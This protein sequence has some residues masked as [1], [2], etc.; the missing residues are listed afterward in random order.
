[1]KICI[2]I[3][4]LVVFLAVIVFASCRKYNDE[5]STAEAQLIISFSAATVPI[6][7]T[8]S[9]TTT[10]INGTDTVRKK[11]I[12]AGSFYSISLKDLKNA[13]YTT[14]TK[15]YAAADT[16]GNRFMYRLNGTVDTQ[17]G[18]S[19]LGPTL[20]EYNLWKPA[21]IYYNAAYDIS[22]A[23]AALPTDPYYE[24]SFPAALEYKY[25]YIDRN[26]YKV[27]TDTTTKVTTKY[28]VN[29]ANVI[30]E[31]A[32]NK[33]FKAN[34][35][36][37]ATFAT[38]AASTTYNAADFSLQLYNQVNNDYKIIVFQNVKLTSN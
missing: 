8:D 29:S 32:K 12:R 28:P 16:S 19:V 3:K 30:L 23:M 37:F 17:K 20:N 2:R 38:Q 31:T 10:L 1:M 11:A 24:L 27:T 33:G 13:T 22:F 4:Y 5:P 9:V 36:A 34:S 35:T 7:T 25:A 21:Y 6:A 14:L 26:L 18:A 15:V